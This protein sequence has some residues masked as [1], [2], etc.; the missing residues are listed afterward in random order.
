MAESLVKSLTGGGKIKARFLHSE[1]FSFEPTFKLWLAANHKP[2]IQGT[3]LA[4]WRRIRLVPFS[5]TIPEAEQNRH[6]A[7]KLADELPGILSWAVEGCLAWQ[8]DGLGVPE[9]VRQATAAYRE[10][11]DPLGDFL[12]ECC[13]TGP[14]VQAKFGDLF[15]RYR[16]WAEEAKEEPLTSRAFA[17]RL[18]EKGFDG[19]KD[20]EARWRIGIRV[21][22]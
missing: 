16:R 21:R 18:T 19:H 13:V 22:A 17:D 9:E 14:T 1:H 4:I 3:G 5:V 7:E 6:L 20:R 15:A 12:G 10:D 8:R 2:V 11:S